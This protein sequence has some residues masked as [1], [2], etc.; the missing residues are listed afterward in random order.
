MA[1]HL[2]RRPPPPRALRPDIPVPVHE[3]VLAALAKDPAKRFRNAGAMRDA[4]RIAAGTRSSQ[5]ELRKLS[6]PSVQKPPAA[7]IEP[8]NAMGPTLRRPILP[9]KAAADAAPAAAAGPAVAPA[10]AAG[11]APAPAAGP[12]PAP[13]AG[14]APAPAPA[15]RSGA[16][17]LLPWAILIIAASAIATA[18]VL[19]HGDK[20]GSASDSAA[21]FAAGEAAASGGSSGSAA[22]GLAPAPADAAIVDAAPPLTPVPAPRV[23]ARTRVPTPTAVPRATPDATTAS[24]PIDPELEPFDPDDR[25]GVATVHVDTD[26]A[27]ADVTIDDVSACVSPCARELTVGKHTIRVRLTGYRPVEQ[28][29]VVDAGKTTMIRIVLDRLDPDGTLDPFDDR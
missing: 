9:R 21:G 16:A 8:L 6:Q 29:V 27:D 2:E 24:P 3:V 1:G 11:P 25:R 26:P 5:P 4:L 22:T 10:A 20:T 23:D 19:A 17:R 28:R 14:P 18:L 7:E 13:A 12:A 15:R